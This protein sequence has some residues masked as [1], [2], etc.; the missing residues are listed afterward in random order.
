VPSGLTCTPIGGTCGT[1]ADCCS[2]PCIS[3]FCHAPS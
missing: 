1:D 2:G 3:G